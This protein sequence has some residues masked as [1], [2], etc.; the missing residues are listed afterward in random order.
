MSRKADINR[1]RRW[2]RRIITAQRA[3]NRV[4]QDIEPAV[5]SYYEEIFRYEQVRRTNNDTRN[6]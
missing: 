5:A 4:I 6:R 2:E 1:Q 3:M